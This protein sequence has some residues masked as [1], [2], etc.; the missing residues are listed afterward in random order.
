ML[1]HA[2]APLL[3]GLGNASG[4]PLERPSR[5]S[6]HTRQSDWT[7]AAYQKCDRR[8]QEK[9]LQHQ[10]DCARVNAWISKYFCGEVC[11]LN[12]VIVA[13]QLPKARDGSDMPLCIQAG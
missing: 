9:G 6:Q 5:S 11:N 8:L 12:P 2:P 13:K 7:V 3:G 1:G 4:V 10:I